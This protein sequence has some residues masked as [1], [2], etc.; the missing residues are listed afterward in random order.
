[1]TTHVR[2]CALGNAVELAGQVAW[3]TLSDALRAR[4]VLADE[5]ERQ[6]DETDADAVYVALGALRAVLTASV[7]PPDQ[8]L[9]DLRTITLSQ[10]VPS[11]VLAYELYDQA[12]RGAEIVARNRIRHPGFVP[13]ATALQ[14]LQDVE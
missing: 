12:S 2:R 9:P 13:A 4:E 3:Q 5:I 7:P 11:L 1:M 14:V 8:D 6:A 10:S